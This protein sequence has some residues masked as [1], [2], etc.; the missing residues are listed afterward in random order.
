MKNLI[1]WEM[2]QTFSSRLF[3]GSCI[4]LAAATVL[5]TLMPL[6]EKEN[7]GFDVFLHGCNNFNSFLL[8][9]I[10]IYSGIHVAGAFE[11]RRVQASVMAGNSRFS[12]LLAKLISF[13]MSIALFCIVTLSACAVMAFGVKG[14]DGFDGSFFREVVLRIAAYTFVEVSFVSVS[15]MLSMFV[16]NLGGSIAVNLAALIGL[17]FLAQMLLE[18]EWAQGFLKFTHVGQTFMLVA[19]ASTKNLIFSVAAS[20]IGLAFTIMMSYIKFRKEELK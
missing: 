13:S 8:L 3:W 5:M 10:G 9:Y 2:K 19:D 14:L 11:E 7:T 17:N 15:F 4:A 16:K 18:K 1:K 12:I 6:F 20:M